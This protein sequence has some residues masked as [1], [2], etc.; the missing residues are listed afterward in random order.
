MA[1]T[2]RNRFC[3]GTVAS[4]AGVRG[5]PV[6]VKPRVLFVLGGPLDVGGAERQLLMVLPLLQQA[7]FDVEL[8]CLGEAGDLA[9][10]MRRHGVTLT[11]MP[12]YFARGTGYVQRKLR[13][14]AGF[15]SVAARISHWRP[16][17]V[18]FFSPTAYTVAGFLTLAMGP[19]IR[20]MSRRKTNQY[21]AG[22]PFAKLQESFLHK[23]C[24]AVL[25]NSRETAKELVREGAP[26]ERVGC[27]YNGV[28]LDAFAE[29]PVRDE[30]RRGLRIDAD[31]LM[32][33]KVANLWSYKGHADL[34]EALATAGLSVPWR[35]FL[36][37]RDEG[38]GRALREQC[39]RS[40]IAE[41]V[42]FIENCADVR[43]YLSAADIGVSASYEEGFSNALL[44]YLA[45]GLPIISTDL[46][47]SVEL[48][49]EAGLIVGKGDV[50]GLAAGFR[51]F[52]NADTR[53][54]YARKAK[55]RARCFSLQLCARQYMQLY[56]SLLEGEALPQEIGLTSAGRS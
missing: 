55:V 37:G 50:V 40:G 7:G 34:I 56:R 14:M 8:H 38:E 51:E 19:S 31:T 52:T 4:A 39:L 48:L 30:V 1:G 17:I 6:T 35:L 24:S 12:A 47:G 22:R 42:V 54:G 49:G 36:I 53:A 18:H 46:G 21:L 10:E 29:L 20:V 15:F 41:Q 23:R 2:A 45:S 11:T 26:I 32:I 33:V 43:P 28:D 3:L 13:A 16:E 44:E 9:S 27:I 25:G 5:Q